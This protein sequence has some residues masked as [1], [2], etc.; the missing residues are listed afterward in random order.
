M[1]GNHYV[2]VFSWLR[3]ARFVSLV[4][5]IT[6]QFHHHEAKVNI[7]ATAREHFQLKL[8]QEQNIPVL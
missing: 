4:I 8:F 1:R 2:D 3:W 5:Y 6:V 7:K